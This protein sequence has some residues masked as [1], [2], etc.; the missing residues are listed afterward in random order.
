MEKEEK[1]IGDMYLAAAF[2]SYNIP[3]TSVDRTVPRRQKFIFTKTQSLTIFTLHSGVILSIQD[4]SLED[5][6]TNFVSDTLMFPPSYPD[7]VRR[8]KSAIHSDD[9]RNIHLEE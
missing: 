2:L 7:A 1:F 4:A 6:E 8:I 9:P 3:L 5:I